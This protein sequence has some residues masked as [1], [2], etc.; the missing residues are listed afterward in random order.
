MREVD[1][2]VDNGDCGAAAIETPDELNLVPTD[3]AVEA[4]PQPV[5]ELDAA[6]IQSASR[7]SAQ[8]LVSLSVSEGL[9]KVRL[10]H[11]IGRCMDLAARLRP[12]PRSFDAL[13]FVNV[14]LIWPPPPPI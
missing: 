10:D 3:V 12:E 14:G 8:R 11:P 13:F 2:C 5:F 6:A 4:L 9:I 1:S 7:Q